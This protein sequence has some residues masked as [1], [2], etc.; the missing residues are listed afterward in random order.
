[1]RAFSFVLCENNALFAFGKN[2]Y[3][4]LVCLICIVFYF[5]Q[6]INKKDETITT[7]TQ[8]VFFVGKSAIQDV[9]AG[10]FH[11]IVLLADGSLYAMGKKECCG[12]ASATAN[13]YSPVPV[14]VGTK[15]ASICCSS[16][17]TIVQTVNDEWY[18]FGDTSTQP[19]PAYGKEVSLT[20][21]RI[22]D[23]FPKGIKIK[24]LVATSNAFFLLSYKNDLYVVGNGGNGEMGMK[25]GESIY[26]WTL[27]KN[28]VADV[29]TGYYNSFVFLQ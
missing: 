20:A 18:A 2:N 29:Q 25:N 10:A 7:P 13:F 12:Q 6:G 14:S 26:K 11:S 24:K 23:V 22:D 19:Q 5:E 4:Q 27:C 28:N 21:S 16:F 1:M 3:G 9:Q 17:C 15:I 8:V